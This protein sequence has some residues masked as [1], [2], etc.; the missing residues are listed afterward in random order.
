MSESNESPVTKTVSASEVLDQA[1]G[2]INAP[3]EEKVE[4]ATEGVEEVAEKAETEKKEEAPKQTEEDRRFAA[5]FAALSRKEKALKQK[6]KQL[7]SRLAEL[8]KKIAPKEEVKVEEKAPLE[9]RLKKDPFTTLSE[10]GLDYETLTRIALN[11]GKMTPELQMQLMREEM[12]QEMDKTYGSELKK[13]REELTAKEQ[14]VA[15]EQEEA[16]VESYKTQIADTIAANKEEFEILAAEGEDARDL[17][18]DVIL[19]HYARTSEANGAEGAEILDVKEA[20]RMVEEH[21][22]EE[23]KKQLALNKVKKLLGTSETPKNEPNKGKKVSPTLS[24]EQSQV[25]SAKKSML[26]DDESKAE[27]AKLIRWVE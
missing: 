2:V 7:E 14:K 6:E 9:Y 17:V 5:K 19:E 4:A 26:S 12:K 3:A 8:E 1:E 10:L 16:Q 21:L 20:A 15:K 18:Y 25:Q 24:N 11:D 27:A 22:L 13:L 23:A